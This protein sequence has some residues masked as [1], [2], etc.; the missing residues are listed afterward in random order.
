MLQ[1]LP[2]GAV[3]GTW[4]ATFTNPANDTGGSV[5][6]TVVLSPLAFL[7]RCPDNGPPASGIIFMMA[8]SGDRM[9]GTYSTINCA[10]LRRGTA[11]LSK[12]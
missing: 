8:L 11:E 10:G 9:N 3:T 4:A 7:G 1:A 5:S 12:Q 2:A 6:S